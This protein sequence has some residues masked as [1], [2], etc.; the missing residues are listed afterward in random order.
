MDFADSSLHFHLR[1]FIFPSAVAS[2]IHKQVCIE[3]GTEG[4]IVK[5]EEHLCNA[6]FKAFVVL[7]LR[8]L[9]APSSSHFYSS[10]YSKFSKIGERTV[11][12]GEDPFLVMNIRALLPNYL[13]V[14]G[15]RQF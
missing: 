11:A 13:S 6:E 1:Q 10:L 9:A 8:V 7:N 14:V 3:V 12:H 15:E 4:L 5:I 2:E